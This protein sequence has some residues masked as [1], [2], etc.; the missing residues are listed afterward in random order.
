M[1]LTDDNYVSIVSAVEQG[2][3]HIFEHPKFVYYLI[4]CNLA[5]ILIIFLPLLLGRFIIPGL[6]SS[7]LSPLA[8]VSTVVAKSDHGWCT[9]P[10][11]GN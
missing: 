4:S 7:E 3:N 1:V 10:G 5:E 9:C 6:S 8:P 11:T 2:R